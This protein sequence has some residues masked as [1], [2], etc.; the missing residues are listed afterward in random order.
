MYES[1][2]LDRRPEDDQ[3]LILYARKLINTTKELITSRVIVY[4]LNV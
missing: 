1:G 4:I 2:K 3:L